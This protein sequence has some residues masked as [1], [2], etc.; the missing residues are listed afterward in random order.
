MFV[1]QPSWGKNDFAV[2]WDIFDQY[3]R[4]KRQ[5]HFNP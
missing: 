5:A 1:P 2:M 3:A 4:E